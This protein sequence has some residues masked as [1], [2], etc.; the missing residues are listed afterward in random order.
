MHGE[1]IDADAERYINSA[2]LWA[3]DLPVNARYTRRPCVRRTPRIS[4]AQVASWYDG[5]HFSFD[6]TSWHF[7]N[8][9]NLLKKYRTRKARVLEIGSWEGR[10]A[11]FFLNFLPRCKVVC[12]DSFAGAG[13]IGKPAVRRGSCAKWKCGL[14]Q[15]SRSSAA[16][17]RRSGR[18]LL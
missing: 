11:I 5:K 10:S 18:R 12:I 8:W 16:G 13:S 2:V 17:S 15:T 6:W 7:P 3:A 4:Q 9:F 1:V 14:M